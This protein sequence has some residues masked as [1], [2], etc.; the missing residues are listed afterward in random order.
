MNFFRT[1]IVINNY[2][3]LTPVRN[4]VGYLL[5]RGYNNIFIIDNDS[6]YPPLMDWYNIIHGKG[7]TVI[8]LPNNLG[9]HAIFNCGMLMDYEYGLR[10]LE[11]VI[12]TDPDI[13]LNPA[14]PSDFAET[15]AGIMK[16]HKLPKLGL[17]LRLD[18]IPEGAYGNQ[19]MGH[20]Q[21]FWVIKV[22]EDLY[23]AQVDTTFCM[24]WR[25]NHHQYDSFRLAG[26]YT[27]R[28]LPWYTKWENI[29]EEEKYFLETADYNSNYRNHYQEWKSKQAS[30][31]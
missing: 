28:H 26:P 17:A 9:P 3:R 4:M 13:E 12:Y 6:N 16:K 8:E 2:N 21:Q 23:N 10:D 15:M 24:L 7:V 1:P 30:G 11:Y 19:Y 20:E 25:P 31:S 14:M 27:C 18:D 22:E 29:T 5:A